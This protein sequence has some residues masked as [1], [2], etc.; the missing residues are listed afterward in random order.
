MFRR[1]VLPPSSGWLS[2]KVSVT[3]PTNTC[4]PFY[5]NINNPVTPEV[6]AVRYC[7][8]PAL[9]GTNP[10]LYCRS[11]NSQ[12]KNMKTFMEARAMYVS[13][14]TYYLYRRQKVTFVQWL[15]EGRS[16]RWRDESLFYRLD[17]RCCSFF[18]RR[19]M[20]IKTS[21]L[22]QLKLEKMAAEFLSL[23]NL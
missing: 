6:Q 8:P 18:P 19:P 17:R 21:E 7:T 22:L 5:I 3:V 16:E 2:L 12:R 23:V 4:K 15:R 10:K 9:Y 1:K 13:Q 14:Y 11:M 20:E